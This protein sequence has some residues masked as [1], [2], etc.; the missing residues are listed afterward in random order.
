M[1]TKTLFF[2]MALGCCAATVVAQQVPNG[3]FENWYTP[4]GASYQDPVDWIT[5][6]AET[7]VVP[8]MGLACTQGSPGQA[9]SSH[10]MTATTRQGAGLG[11][12]PSLVVAGNTTTHKPGF[13]YAFRPTALTGQVAYGGTSDSCGITVYLTK[14]IEA[15]HSHAPVGTG[16]KSWSWPPSMDWVPFTIG[17]TYVSNEVPDSAFIVISSNLNPPTAG[18]YINVD[19]LAFSFP[20]GV[21]EHDAAAI[22]VYPS[23][24]TDLLHVGTDRAMARVTLLDITG[25]TVLVQP[26][27]GNM[28]QVDVADLKQGRYL[29]QV[30]MQDGK[31]IVRSFVKE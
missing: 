1:K 20:V 6:N 31:R 11:L 30:E 28:A 13:P 22:Q 15:S 19:N 5:L 14:W 26:E 24:A 7:S 3:D 4:A 25:R 21:A 8:G 9:G 10:Y 16:T 18:N 27:T 12:V 29:V 23:P 17:I 2:S